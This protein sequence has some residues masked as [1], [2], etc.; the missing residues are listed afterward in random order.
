MKLSIIVPIYNVE[1]Y[2]HE[3]LDSLINQT[4]TNLEI[5]LVNDGST[6]D[7]YNICESYK[8]KDN[9]IIIIHKENGGL[10]SARNSGL[11]VATGEYVTFVDSDDFIDLHTYELLIDELRKEF[12]D[13]ISMKIKLVNETGKYL[14]DFI[15]ESINLKDSKDCILELLQY[16]GIASVDNKLFKREIIQKFLFNEDRLNEDVLFLIKLYS[17]VEIKQ[18]D[19]LLGGYNYRQR[20]G[21]VTK[22]GFNK[23]IEDSIYNAKDI[24]D[25]V[26]IKYPILKL[27]IKRF[28]L[29]QL[30]TYFALIP[31]KNMKIE[32]P[33]Y[34]FAKELFN[35]N[36]RFLK[37]ARIDLPSKLFLF[38][39]KIT[40]KISKHIINICLD[41]FK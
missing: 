28:I 37:K 20:E 25:I 32:N 40:P 33:S 16:K 3:C 10:S 36:Y 7:C 8:S 9:R 23:A 35:S 34:K 5:I 41:I 31:F 30:R 6:D 18:L 13:I 24:E 15:S 21:S 27:E 1:K 29:F 38:T 14:S 22:S 12:Y 26:M 2:L 4:Y 19:T 39:Y 17:E 11:A